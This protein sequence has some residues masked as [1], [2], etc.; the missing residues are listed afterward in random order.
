MSFTL[1]LPFEIFISFSVYIFI[2]FPFG[3]CIFASNT[4]KNYP[5]FKWVCFI[6][7]H[8]QLFWESCIH[9][10]YDANQS[11]IVLNFTK[12]LHT[13]PYMVTKRCDWHKT[14]PLGHFM[15]HFT[16]F[17]FLCFYV[18]EMMT[19]ASNETFLHDHMV[20]CGALQ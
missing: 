16:T 5:I 11:L 1:P 6:P 8:Y 17:M 3:I 19:K 10:N 14:F 7:D 2:R 20:S 13:R 15:I 12:E 4:Y 18:C 9:D